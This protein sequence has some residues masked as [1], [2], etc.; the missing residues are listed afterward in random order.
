MTSLVVAPCS[1][2]AANFAVMRWHYSRAFPTSK[3]T[4]FGVWEDGRFIGAVIF[5]WGAQPKLGRQFGA[6]MIETSELVRVALTE[7]VSPVSQIVALAIKQLKQSSPGLRVIVSFADPVQGHRGGI[8]QAGNWV[9]TGRSSDS[10][11]CK[12]DGRVIHPRTVVSMLKGKR[13]PG[14]ST[15]DALTRVLGKPVTVVRLPGKHRYVYPLD[16]RMRRRVE[17]ASQPYPAV[18]VSDS[19]TVLLQGQG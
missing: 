14:E 9:Y 10:A 1:R 12:V 2:E 4:T 16:R 7:H 15:V 5:G 3:L 13:R 19:D 17:M 18:E 8:Y 6:S 11:F